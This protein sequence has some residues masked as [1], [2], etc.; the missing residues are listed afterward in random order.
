MGQ[1]VSVP[2]VPTVTETQLTISGLMCFNDRVLFNVDGS[3]LLNP[4]TGEVQEI[5]AHTGMG[6]GYMW[7]NSTSTRIWA[8]GGV[9]WKNVDNDWKAGVKISGGPMI[10]LFG[11]TMPLLVGPEVRVGVNDVTLGVFAKFILRVGASQQTGALGA[12]GETSSML[13]P[14]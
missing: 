13:F 11:S 8:L 10:Y 5:P 3:I 7:G 12:G 14:N 9:D 2:N 6:F 1:S 4:E